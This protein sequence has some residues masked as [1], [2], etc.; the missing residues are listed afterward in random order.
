[1]SKEKSTRSDEDFLARLD[2]ISDEIP[3]TD[4]EAEILL[5]EA[6][7]DAQG[8]LRRL[9]SRIESFDTQQKQERLA[10]ADAE[11]RAA[12]AQLSTP[13]RQRP[14]AEL[15]ARLDEL[16]ALK[17][18]DFL[19][20]AYDTAN[21]RAAAIFGLSNLIIPASITVLKGLSVLG[22]QYSSLVLIFVITKHARGPCPGPK[23]G[24]GG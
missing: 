7:V 8:A 2:R 13:T 19:S 4:A 1:M 5:Q 18:F 20:R 17:R 15:L 10:R 11:R 12:L 9:L 14:R 22:Y 3:V 16:K 23:G 24:D 21:T 6:G